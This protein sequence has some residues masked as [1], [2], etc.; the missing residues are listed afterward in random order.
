VTDLFRRQA[1][2]H[3]RERFHGAIILT[4]HWSFTAL[5]IVL[6][7]LAIAIPIFAATAGFTRKEAVTGVLVPD[8]GLIRLVAPQAGIVTA[9]PATDGQ[10]VRP[11]EIL[12]VLSGERA[13]ALGSTES[14]VAQTLRNRQGQIEQ[15]LQQLEQQTSAQRASLDQRLASLGAGLQEQGREWQLQSDKVQV[16]REVA[17][18]YPDLVTSGAVSD[19]EAKEKRAELIDQQAR[20]SALAQARL[21]TQRELLN[22][23]S[24]RKELPLV[25][26]QQR[27]PLRRELENLLQ[28]TAENESSR[29]AQIRA[30]TAGHMV[31]VLAVVGQAVERGQPLATLVSEG[32]ALEGELYAPAKAIAF[33][34]PGTTVWLRYETFPYQKFGQ[35]SG[36][37]RD[38]SRSAIAL[39]ELPLAGA[40]ATERGGELVYRINVTLDAQSIATADGP[41]ALRP[42]MQVQASLVAE[43]RTLLEWILEPLAGMK[44]R[45]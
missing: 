38:V 6:A 7:C 12:F 37:V 39:R 35:F 15:Q 43:R 30:H 1:V 27:L 18:R 36:R 21:A 23:Q 8:K 3:Q 32:A 25:T 26:E 29:E 14:T 4:R 42:G 34:R 17:Q 44:A 2:D 28:Q 9:A 31:S 16:L 20:L 40:L 33:V 11:G 5:T 22:L 45:L 10:A 41:Q 13:N 24:Q 19:V